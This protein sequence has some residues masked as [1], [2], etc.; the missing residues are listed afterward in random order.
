MLSRP[1][2]LVTGSSSGIGAAIVAEYAARGYDVVVNYNSGAERA[3]KIGAEI[4]EDHGVAALV[5]GA[6]LADAEAAYA[7]VDGAGGAHRGGGATSACRS[8]GRR[9]RLDVAPGHARRGGLA[10]VH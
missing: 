7:L 10:R 5:L 6:D 3:E 1:V 9:R 4:R 2:C 8:G